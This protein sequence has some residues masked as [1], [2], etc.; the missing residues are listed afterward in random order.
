MI[1]RPLLELHEALLHLHKVLLDSE[2]AVYETSV[3]PINSPNHFFQPPA[4]ADPLPVRR[5]VRLF[6][7][8]RIQFDCKVML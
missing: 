4:G 8:Q 7:G 1:R 6:V 3:G 2:R 5:G